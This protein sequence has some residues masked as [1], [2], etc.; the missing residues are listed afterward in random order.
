MRW[1]TPPAAWRDPEM[2]AVEVIDNLTPIG[3]I[4]SSESQAREPAIVSPE[5]HPPD[6]FDC[7]NAMDRFA[8][9][10]AGGGTCTITPL[11]GN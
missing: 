6:R 7:G 10:P 1:G 4:P 5:S 3:V 2:Q 8:H 11:F 9:F